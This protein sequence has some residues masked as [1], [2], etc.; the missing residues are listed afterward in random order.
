MGNGGASF[1][2]LQI[3]FPHR[4][5]E[6]QLAASMHVKPTE[7]PAWDTRPSAG[8]RTSNPVPSF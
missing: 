1:Q 7:A 8:S 5:S 3:V 2:V 6:G 4:A